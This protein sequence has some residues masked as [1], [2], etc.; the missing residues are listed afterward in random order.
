MCRPSNLG[1]DGVAMANT[2]S[3][4]SEGLSAVGTE[5]QVELGHVAHPVRHH[6]GLDG[7][8]MMPAHYTTHL[9]LGS[10]PV[11]LVLPHGCLALLAV[12]A[13]QPTAR[14]TYLLA[15]HNVRLKWFSRIGSPLLQKQCVGWVQGTS[16]GRQGRVWPN[17]LVRT[18][19]CN[20]RAGMLI[21]LCSLHTCK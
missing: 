17:I 21:F 3:E 9:A 1:R 5:R 14:Q 10:W 15:R 16:S 18:H 13:L 2:A 19:A 8:C 11:T 6:R 20:T 7:A 12:P 4:V